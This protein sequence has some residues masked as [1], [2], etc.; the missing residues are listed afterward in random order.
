M[1]L[2][3][4]ILFRYTI[5]LAI[6]LIFSLSIVVKIVIIQLTG[7]EK[8]G[9]KVKYLEDRESVI[10]GIRGDICAHDGRVLSTSVPFYEIRFDLG[11]P[12]VR[13]VF[14]NEVSSLSKKLSK[15]FP[16]KSSSQFKK[17]L[18]AAYKRKDRYY[19]IHPQKV[20]YEQLKKI[21]TFPIFKLGK[22]KGGFIV[23]QENIRFSPQGRMASRTIGLVNKGT[24]DGYQGTKGISGIEGMYEDYLKGNEGL[25]VQQNL[26]GRWVNIT[27]IEPEKGRDIYTTIDVYLQDVTETYLRNQ[28]IKSDAEYGTA[29]VMEVSTGKIRA[30]S[31]LGLKNGEYQEIYNYAYGHEGCTEPGS[32]FKLA[33]M[34]VAME[35][36]LVDTSDVFDIEDGKWKIY[37]KTIYDSDYGHGEHGKMTVKEI[38][39]RSSNV[40][41][42][43]IINKC[44]KGREKEFINRIYRLGLNEKLDLGFKGESKPYIKYPTDDNWWGTSLTWI[45]HGYELQISPLQILTL[46]NAVANDGKMMKPMFVESIR[47]NGDIQKIYEPEVL[48]YS[49]CSNSTLRKLKSLL[50]GVVENGTAKN[51]RSSKYRFAGKTGTAKIYDKKR[52]YLDSRYRASFAGYFPAENPKY[53][54]VVVISEPKGDYYGGSIAGPVFRNIA[55]CVMST[56]INIESVQKPKDNKNLPPLFNGLEKETKVVCKELDLRYKSPKDDADW[57]STN[58]EEKI[59]E[60]KGKNYV[61]GQIPNVFGMGASDAIFIIEGAGYKCNIS[62]IGKVVRQSPQPGTTCGRGQVVYLSL[63]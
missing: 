12:T 5:L 19:L 58:E 54:C 20:T 36:G 11:A 2:R 6:V 63:S 24:G 33:S 53:S 50:E 56:D 30:I 44:Y 26:S 51:I 37:D 42:A 39:E 25:Q 49:I 31:N 22:F 43:K 29:V 34:L 13:A 23:V 9:S 28:L 4:I 41:I 35:E 57:V 59:V 38:F 10:E 17:E 18:L 40:G 14:N 1:N 55:D 46:Y 61:K 3:K 32:T 27:S 47:D 60:L 16:D 45:S 21:E 62:G 52:G 15:I 48:K 8:W 7:S